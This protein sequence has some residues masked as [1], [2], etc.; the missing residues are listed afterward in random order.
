MIRATMAAT[1]SKDISKVDVLIVG[2]GPGGLA[3]ANSV[4][5]HVPNLTCKVLLRNISCDEQKRHALQ[6]AYY[7]F[8]RLWSALQQ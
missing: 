7:M 5:L 8:H 1:C 6:Q 4:K 3:L 2:G